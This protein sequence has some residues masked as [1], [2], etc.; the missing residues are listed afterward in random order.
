M[1]KTAPKPARVAASFGRNAHA[2]ETHAELQRM[3]AAK[4]AASLPQLEAPKV[5]E[6]ACGTGLFSRYLLA[7]YPDGDFTFS[8][9]SKGML[10]E[11]KRNIAHIGTA[12]RRFVEVDAN[13]PGDLERY[14]L[15]ATSMSL[16]W[17]AD[18]AASLQALR[19]HLKPGG[20]LVYAGL[21]E[22][23]FAEWRAALAAEGLPDGIVPLPPLPGVKD[24]EALVMEQDGLAF[25]RR[26][27]AIG[28][29]TPAEGY[30]SLPPGA[31]RRALRRLERSHG[32]KVTWEIVYGRL[33]SME[34]SLAASR[35]SPSMMPL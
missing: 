30:R 19:A 10:A 4:L 22:N 5:L 13:A 23:C 3:V 12:P 35:S 20:A 17:L 11:A 9:L 14:D 27:K 33:S 34:S 31:L 15:I 26:L 21:G 28:G 7:E 18:P 25:L 32:G 2:Y 24:S 8:D 16:H 1:R 6:L 29:I